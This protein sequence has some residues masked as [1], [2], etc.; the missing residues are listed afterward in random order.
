MK[1]KLFLLFVLLCV[2]IFLGIVNGA[3]SISL[4][5]IFMNE[6]N[7]I[8]NM[9]LIRTLAAIIAG[10]CLAV[11]GIVMQ[12]VLKNPLAEPYLL[13]TSSGAGLAGMVAVILGLS[14]NYVP[15]AAFIG[16]LASIVIV[17]NLAKERGR[18]SDKSLILSGVIVSIASSSVIV[19][20]VSL[21]GNEAQHEMTWWLW[22]SLQIYDFNLFVIVSIIVLFGLS[23]LYVFSQ[24]MNAISMG[25]EEAVHLGVD[26][27]KIKKI[28]I[29]ITSLIVSALICVVG[30]IG[31]VGLVVPHIMRMLVGN[32]HKILIPVSCLAASIF[33]ILCD[34]LSRTIFSPFEIP[35]GVVTSLIGCPVFIILLKREAK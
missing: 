11:S 29:I 2:A 25:D 5:D 16:A 27:D 33:M 35:I 31:F 20:L 19:L 13:G 17:Y 24:D 10:S 3:V 15:F 6:N 7:V 34:V 4:S 30:I 22:G 8:F 18:I 12:A 28:L 1:L 32:N 9:R 14:R 21:F 26:A 23:G